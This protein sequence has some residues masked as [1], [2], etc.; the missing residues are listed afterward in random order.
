MRSIVFFFCMQFKKVYFTHCTVSTIFI[1]FCFQK[2]VIVSSVAIMHVFREFNFVLTLVTA[3]NCS[4]RL[5]M[6]EL[7]LLLRI[8]LCSH[9]TCYNP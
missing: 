6:V 8:V 4:N 7:F 1:N 3:A 2:S 9:C 5:T